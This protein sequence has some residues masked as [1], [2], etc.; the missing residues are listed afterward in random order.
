MGLQPRLVRGVDRRD[1]RPAGAGEHARCGG[2]QGAP[3]AGPLPKHIN[4]ALVALMFRGGSSI[5][6]V[7]RGG[8]HRDPGRGGDKR[9]GEEQC[10]RG[11]REAPEAAAGRGGRRHVAEVVPLDKCQK[12]VIRVIVSAVGAASLVAYRPNASSRA[13]LVTSATRSLCRGACYMG[14]GT[15]CRDGAR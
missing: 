4:A 15:C 6:R 5:W 13:G 3:S 9:G 1:P 12:L 14:R 8:L 7:P 11:A 10:R 2:E